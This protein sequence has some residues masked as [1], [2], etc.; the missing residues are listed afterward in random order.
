M[1]MPGPVLGPHWPPGG[2]G[3][4]AGQRCRGAWPGLPWTRP[5]RTACRT[6]R[7]GPG[8]EPDSEKLRFNSA[9]SRASRLMFRVLLFPTL[10]RRYCRFV[11]HGVIMLRAP[12]LTSKPVPGLFRGVR[13]LLLQIGRACSRVYADARRSARTKLTVLILRQTAS[14]APGPIPPLAVHP[15]V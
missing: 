5:G 13:H 8:R 3:P 15:R 10:A 14:P 1:M 7:V 12:A 11:C 4:S 2:P 9:L 6:R